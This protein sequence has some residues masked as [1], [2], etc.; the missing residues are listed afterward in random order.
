M[1]FFCIFLSISFFIIWIYS[2]I[3]EKENVRLKKQISKLEKDL[4]QNKD[5]LN[6]S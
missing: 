3:V 4:E 1:I 2:K 5:D 6:D